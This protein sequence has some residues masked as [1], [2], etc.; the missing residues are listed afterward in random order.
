LI[1]K[2]NESVMV[3]ASLSVSTKGLS[4]V[5]IKESADNFEFIVGD[6]HHHCPSW[7]ADFL[8]PRIAA[9]HA[10]A[11]TL[12]SCAV[13]TVDREGHFGG[14]VGLGR[15]V[16][17]VLTESNHD[18]CL[19]ISAELRNGELGRTLFDIIEG[20][21]SV[22]NV[23]RQIQSLV[24]MGATV[25]AEIWFITSHFFEI[26]SSNVCEQDYKIMNEVVHHDKLRIRSEDSLYEIIEERA[27][28]DARYFGLFDVIHFEFLS[29]VANM[30]KMTK[31]TIEMT[32]VE[33]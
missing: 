33:L 23:V 31:M 15:G 9:I 30:A 25:Q 19:S 4:R 28:S 3:S 1:Q 7:V 16:P 22:E 26:S 21:I 14:F 5:P 18:F 24:A 10:I 27:S 11:G 8:S 2:V 29:S 17:L 20:N 12:L 32:D 6:V 13:E